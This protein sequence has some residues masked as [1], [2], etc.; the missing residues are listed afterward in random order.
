MTSLS[1]FGFSSSGPIAKAETPKGACAACGDFTRVE[2]ICILKARSGD[3][4]SFNE[5]VSPGS[6]SSP[7]D[8]SITAYSVLGDNR[9]IAIRLNNFRVVRSSIAFCLS[10][11]GS[12]SSSQRLMKLCRA[13]RFF[14]CTDKF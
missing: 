14:D 1:P 13:S 6:L 8:D 3:K 5:T 12:F 10:A 4:G 9:R 7:S 11:S 2:T